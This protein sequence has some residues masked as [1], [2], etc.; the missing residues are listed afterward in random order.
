V[1]RPTRLAAPSRAANTHSASAAGS[2]ATNSAIPSSTAR[3]VTPRKPSSRDIANGPGSI[4]SNN[5]TV[6]ATSSSE[7]TDPS[8]NTSHTGSPDMPKNLEAGSDKTPLP[9]SENRPSQITSR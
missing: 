8:S 4:P 6:P 1:T 2:V 7:T 3:S 5:A 9:V